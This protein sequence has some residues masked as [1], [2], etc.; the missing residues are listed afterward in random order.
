MQMWLRGSPQ[1]LG[2][3]LGVGK[4]NEGAQ[5]PREGLCQPQKLQVPFAGVSQSVICQGILQRLRC[6]WMGEGAWRL[7]PRERE[8]D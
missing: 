8:I 7:T 4:D 1:H 2:V 5:E 3:R 6:V